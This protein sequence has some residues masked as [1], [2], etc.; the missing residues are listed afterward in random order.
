MQRELIRFIQPFRYARGLQVA[1]CRLQVAAKQERHARSVE[2][3]VEECWQR[4]T[5]QKEGLLLLGI[6]YIILVCIKQKEGYCMY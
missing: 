2:L 4:W 3:Q 6:S 1:C 5:L